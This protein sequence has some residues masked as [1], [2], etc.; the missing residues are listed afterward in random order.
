MRK[1][2]WGTVKRTR[3]YEKRRSRRRRNEERK[4][5]R[6]RNEKRKRRKRT[7]TTRT[8]RTKTR[9]GREGGRGGRRVEYNK[10][11]AHPLRN[12]RA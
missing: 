3:R 8:R 6:R 12:D 4:S 10:S 1:E 5:R 11:K 9:L 7:G 2:R